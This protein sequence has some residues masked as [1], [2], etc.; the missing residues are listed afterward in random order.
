MKRLSFIGLIVAALGLLAAAGAQERFDYQVRDD[1]FRAFGG[2]EAAFK[3]ATAKIEETLAANPDHAEALVWR[4]AGTY[5]KA[6]QV[7]RAGDAAGARALAAVAMADMDRA[8]ALAPRTIG[9][10]IPRA[11]VLL[12]AARNQPD[13]ARACDLAARAAADYETALA[14]RQPEF[15]KLG[16][17]NRGEYLSGLAEAWAIA[18]ER[19]KSET[20]LRR[21]LAELPGSPYA[22]R[23]SA[24]LGDR[25][26]RRP[27]NC[28]TCH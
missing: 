21:I 19:D 26:D 17:H 27:L 14:L 12:V 25:S 24:R 9:V 5:W 16:Q 8:L 15:A 18:G 23:A 6:G 22:E 2:N 7:F 20:Y 3:N 13:P 1:M 11:A 10:L 4:G 28:Q